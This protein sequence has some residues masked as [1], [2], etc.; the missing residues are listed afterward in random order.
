MN[1]TDLTRELVAIPSINPNS[2]PE[3]MTSPGEA[4]MAA[5]VKAI[6]QRLRATHIDTWEPYPGRPS[7]SAYLDFGAEETLIFDAHLDTVPVEGM[8]V[9]PFGGEVRDGRIYGRGAC[10][11]KGPMAAMLCAVERVRQA[12]DEG[13]KAR[14]NVLFAAVCDEEAGFGGVKSFVDRIEMARYAKIAGVIVAEPTL[15]NAVAAHKG[16]ARWSITTKGVAAHSSSPHLGVNAIYKM[17][18]VIDRLE[19]YAARLVQR[20]AHPSLGTPTLSI[21]TIHGG[22]AANIVPDSCVIQIDRR[23]V[24]GESPESVREDLLKSLGELELTLSDPKVSAPAMETPDDHPLVKQAIAAGHSA[25][26]SSQV[27][28]ANYCT[29]ASQYMQLGLPTVVYGPGSIA[30]AHTKDEWVAIE[31]LEI[32]VRAY[33][34]LVRGV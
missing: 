6:F 22:S 1:V 23:L 21:G 12:V 27:E 9:D 2:L 28:H 13:A 19:Q 32:G 5:R 31:Q 8:T 14:Y 25:G 3:G 17:A 24:P 11:V 33:E 20:P 16:T 34:G 15:L 30:Q 18:P 10:D 4:E 26:A 29:D 7:V